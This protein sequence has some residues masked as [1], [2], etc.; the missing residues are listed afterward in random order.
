MGLSRVSEDEWLQAEFDRVA[1]AV[2]FDENA[3]AVLILPEAEEAG[4]EVAAL[5][6]V[7]GGLREAAR[8]CWED[9]CILQRNRAGDHVLTG[10]AVAFPTDWRLVDKIGL[11][12]TAVHAPIH[13]YAEQLAA[14]VD[15]F[16]R[17][18]APGPIYGRSNWFVVASDV[19]RYMPVDDPADRFAHVD[20]ANVGSTLFLRS[21][22]QTLRRL[23]QTDAVLFTIGIAV[24]PL[25]ALSSGAVRK[26]ANDIASTATG[27]H[28]RRAAPF[29]AGALAGYARR[30]AEEP[31][32]CC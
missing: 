24:K 23:P 12:L 7:E 14:G 20:A 18:L 25:G 15:H 3:D 21:E 27:E 26:I 16:F 4:R 30:R 28:E 6:G 8:A 31:T 5:V 29:Y 32:K 11:K 22:R 9:L 13:G 1:R 2:A 19:W 10:G 17:T